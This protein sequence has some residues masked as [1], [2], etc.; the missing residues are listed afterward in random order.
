MAAGISGILLS[1]F[2]DYI[3]DRCQ[4]VIL[5]GA[6]SEWT[7][8]KAGIPQG[9]ILGPL[10]SLIYINDIFWDIDSTIKLFADDTSLYIIADEPVHAA[11]TLNID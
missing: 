1:W 10:L 8:I 2:S 6:S 3:D 7:P 4:R 11:Q 9:S 5:P